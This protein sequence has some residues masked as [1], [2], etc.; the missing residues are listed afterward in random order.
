MGTRSSSRLKKVTRGKRGT[1][2]YWRLQGG[3]SGSKGLQGVTGG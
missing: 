2:G 1:G 3:Y